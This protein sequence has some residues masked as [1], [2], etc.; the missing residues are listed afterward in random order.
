MNTAGVLRQTAML[1]DTLA[2]NLD[3]DIDRLEA[4]KQRLQDAAR[5]LRRRAEEHEDVEDLRL[6]AGGA[7][8]V[9]GEA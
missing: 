5:K 2:H 8:R 6:L 9:R 7:V 1:Y 4:E 3:R